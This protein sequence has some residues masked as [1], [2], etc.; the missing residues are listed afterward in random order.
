MRYSNTM[1][2]KNRRLLAARSIG[3]LLLVSCLFSG[4]KSARVSDSLYKEGLPGTA[5]WAVLP[6]ISFSGIKAGVSIQLERILMV[7]LPAIGI[8]EPHL[9]PEEEVTPHGDSTPQAT[10]LKKAEEWA[11]ISGLSFAV[12]GEV[13]EWAIAEDGVP[14]VSISLV[15]S[16]VRTSE[17][18]WSNSGTVQGEAWDDPYDTSRTLFI[19]LLQ[20]LPINNPR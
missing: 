5:P 15:V 8:V 18:L 1:N 9:Y 6:F 3:L 17:I 20:T 11:H 19:D 12:A 2:K 13:T 4:C 14:S 16:D 7:H 10:R